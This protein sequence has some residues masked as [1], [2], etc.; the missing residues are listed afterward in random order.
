M[1][2]SEIDSILTKVESLSTENRKLLSKLLVDLLGKTG[3]RPKTQNTLQAG[4]IS[5]VYIDTAPLVYSVEK[6]S[7]YESSLR[8][9]WAASK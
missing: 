1:S 3:K 5:V 9:L 6:H 2:T 8:P 7:E 4:R